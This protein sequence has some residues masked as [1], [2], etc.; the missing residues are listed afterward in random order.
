MSHLQRSVCLTNGVFATPGKALSA[1]PPKT[2]IMH[3]GG[4]FRQRRRLQEAPPRRDEWPL[5]L[6]CLRLHGRKIV[7]IGD[8][9]AHAC[10]DLLL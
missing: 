10:G 4:Y 2:P 3:G 5:Q 8:V 1:V 7:S 9:L 6:M